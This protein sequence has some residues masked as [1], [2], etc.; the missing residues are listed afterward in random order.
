MSV[1][2]KV[3]FILSLIF[4]VNGEEQ[5]IEIEGKVVEI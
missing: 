5:K 1:N 4:L 2:I 3:I